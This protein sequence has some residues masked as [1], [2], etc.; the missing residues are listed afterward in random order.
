MKRWIEILTNAWRERGALGD[1]SKQQT[2]A[3]FLP[4]ALE[5]QET[6]P[7]PLARWLGIS[8][9]SLFLIA[10]IWA[11]FGSVDVVASADGKI[12]PSSRIK[13]VQPLA[14]GFVKSILVKEGQ[15]VK[16]GDVLVELD[17]T[18]TA[19]DQSR[20]EKELRTSILDLADA[21]T[22][23]QLLTDEKAT[24]ASYAQINLVFSDETLLT[25]SE[26]SIHQQMV[27]QQW[28]QYMAQLGS[29]KSAREK[30]EAEKRYS[31]ETIKKLEQ[32]LPMVSKRAEGM[33]SLFDKQL[34]SETQFMEVEQ[35]RIEN[36][37]NLAAEKQ[38]QQQ[39]AAAINEA[40][41]QINALQADT[42]NKILNVI[43]E[44]T[45]KV[46]SLQEELIKATDV[47]A[48]QTL[49][50][51]VNGYVQELAI[52]TVGGIVTEAQKLMS[53]VPEEE[54]LEVEVMLGNNDIGFVQKDMIAEIK[55]HTFPFTKYGL[56]DA[57]ITNIS[58]DA[59]VDEK[60]G[61]VYAMHLK[62][63]RNSIFVDTKDV[64]LLPGMAVTAEVKTDKRRVIEYFLAPIL[65]YKQESIRER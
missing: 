8:L 51:P 43:V 16:Q 7:N 47:N 61:L 1:A 39:L 5:I 62:M 36:V 53:I 11:C 56:I 59:I 64:K 40:A 49:Y 15:Y 38:R 26:K 42:L 65:Q 13:T 24:P 58:D 63:H 48:K 28:Q 31:A 17:Q 25:E 29:L 52:S 34:A 4:A 46:A 18:I 54:S 14:K 19:A 50:A 20:M 30:A 45:N 44:N 37:Q 12:I 41:L 9:V 35:Q 6:P 3:E 55:I 21:K 60:R 57:T 22:L 27:W 2:L 32:T 23:S 10:V 33:K